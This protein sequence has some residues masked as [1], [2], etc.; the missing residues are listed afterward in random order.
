[1]DPGLLEDFPFLIWRD[2]NNVGFLIQFKGLLHESSTKNV[3]AK[4]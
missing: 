3:Y 2:E 1:M 4:G